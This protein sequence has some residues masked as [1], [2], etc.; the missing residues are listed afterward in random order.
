MHNWKEN[1]PK[2]LWNKFLLSKMCFIFILGNIRYYYQCVYVCGAH[3]PDRDDNFF[4]IVA[5]VLQRNTLAPYL[6][7]LCLDCVLYTSTMRDAEDTDD[8]GL[9][10]IT[11]AEAEFLQHSQQQVTG[12][13]GLYMNVNK[14]VFNIKN[15]LYSKWLACKISRSIPIPWQ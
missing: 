10:T 4:N 14:T 7:I 8:L 6:F 11:P 13:T 1:L 2:I 9:L 15:H 5:G 12:G 3:S